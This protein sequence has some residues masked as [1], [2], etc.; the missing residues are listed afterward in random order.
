MI[1]RIGQPPT[2][3]ISSPNI[4]KE[5][6]QTN[7]LLFSDRPV[8]SIMTCLGHHNYSL[9]FLPVSPLWKDLR[10]ICNELLFSSKVLDL[11]QDLRHKKLIELLDQMQRYGRTG[12]AIDIGHA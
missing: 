2:V 3:I 8:P 9:G 4:A 1:L 10:K 11:S 5:V 12:K 7:D 6:L